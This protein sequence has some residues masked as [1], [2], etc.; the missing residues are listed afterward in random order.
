MFTV[1]FLNL[2]MG[3]QDKAISISVGSQ[4]IPTVYPVCNVACVG[5]FRWLAFVPLY[6]IQYLKSLLW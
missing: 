6:S 2:D 3:K 5:S 1:G 4:S